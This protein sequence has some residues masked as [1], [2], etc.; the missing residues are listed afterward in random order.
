MEKRERIFQAFWLP[1]VVVNLGLFSF[2]VHSLWAIGFSS[3]PNIMTAKNDPQ[4]GSQI[5]IALKSFL[6]TQKPLVVV[7]FGQCSE[8]TLRNLS[9]W[10]LML[11]RWSDEIKGVIVASEKE[12]VLR[13]WAKEMGWKIPFVADEGGKILKQLNAYFLPRVYGFSPEGKLVWKQDSIATTQLEAIRAVVEAVKGKEYAKK[14]F[15]RK[16]A[17]A[18]VLENE[19]QNPAPRTEHSARGGER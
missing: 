2:L 1:A 4:L 17:W 13:K 11:N 16:P 19:A 10:V 8:C 12:Q 5:P 3:R 9:G 7:A 15:E 18:K 14:V 6:D